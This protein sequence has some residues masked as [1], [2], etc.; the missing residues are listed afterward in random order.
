MVICLRRSAGKT[1]RTSVLSSTLSTP[2]A[3][4]VSVNCWEG[5]SVCPLDRVNRVSDRSSKTIVKCV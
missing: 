1:T 4:L 3:G 2:S 5:M